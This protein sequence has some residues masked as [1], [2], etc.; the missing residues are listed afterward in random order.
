MSADSNNSQTQRG[1]KRFSIADTVQVKSKRKDDQWKKF[2]DD[3]IFAIDEIP[4]EFLTDQKFKN[5]T[6][7]KQEECELKFVL[8]GGAH[9]VYLPAAR[10]I[11]LAFY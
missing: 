5:Y 7:A 3:T 2:D 11:L 10:V 8:E 4:D 6:L 9:I 1:S